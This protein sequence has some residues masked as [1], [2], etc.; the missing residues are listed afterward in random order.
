ML[1]ALAEMRK[2]PKIQ[3]DKTGDAPPTASPYTGILTRIT[4]DF[5]KMARHQFKLEQQFDA[6]VDEIQELLRKE[7][8]AQNS[9]IQALVG[10]LNDAEVRRINLAQGLIQLKDALDLIAGALQA[11]GLTE[12]LDQMEQLDASAIR[13][14]AENGLQPLG[15]ETY[16]DEQR[17]EIAGTAADSQKAYKAILAVEQKGYSYLGQVLRKARVIVNIARKDESQYE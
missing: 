14:M 16:F 1:D 9:A 7:V 8:A 2:Y 12:W 13:V 3:L 17:H 10:H 6:F 5:Q 11:A 4:D 15:A